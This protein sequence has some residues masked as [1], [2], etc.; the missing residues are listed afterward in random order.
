MIS[1]E[2][3]IALIRK[4][5]VAIGCAVVALACG[6]ALYWRSDLIPAAEAELEQ[7]AAE[8]RRIDLNLRHAAQLPE[9][10]AALSGAMAEIEL[11]LVSA[12]ELA[13]NLQY[14]YKL[15]TETGTKLLDLKQT[16]IR[17][18]AKT[19]TKDSFTTVPFIL[20]VS[21]DYVSLLQ[22]LRRLE[23][24]AHYPRVAL[25]SITA[26]GLDRTGP[27]SLQLNLDLLGRP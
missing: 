26:S 15:E 3:L 24:G 19:A 8:G 11:R 12:D 18:Q 7:K 22:F 14:F 13:K 27:L 9:Q 1:N 25:A 10:L 16:T 21:G 6:A 4:N 23:S 2:D 20:S 5:P 17:N